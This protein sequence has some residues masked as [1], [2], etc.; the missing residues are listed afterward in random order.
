MAGPQVGEYITGGQGALIFL[1]FHKLGRFNSG[2]Y[3]STVGSKLDVN[4]CKQNI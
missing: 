3:N 2:E 1:Y 4:R